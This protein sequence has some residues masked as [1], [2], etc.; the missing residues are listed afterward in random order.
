MESH[1]IEK[2]MSDEKHERRPP[3]TLD[4]YARCLRF[5]TPPGGHWRV[6]SHHSYGW[7]R[8]WY[9]NEDEHREVMAAASRVIEKMRED[10]DAYFEAAKSLSVE[11]AQEYI[12]D[13][14]GSRA[15][16]E[17]IGVPEPV[18]G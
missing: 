7:P 10:P 15:I 5:Q 18:S 1:N 13:A 11:E 16:R 3:K 14:L 6:L 9:G 8:R 4:A 2:R 17:A 12:T